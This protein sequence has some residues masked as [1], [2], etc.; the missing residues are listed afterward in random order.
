MLDKT[1]FVSYGYLKSAEVA[2]SVEQ[3][4]ENPRVGGSIP[5]LGTFL[6]ASFLVINEPVRKI[7]RAIR[8]PLRKMSCELSARSTSWC[9]LN[10]V[11]ISGIGFLFLSLHAGG[12][13]EQAP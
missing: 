8:H 5:S 13:F 3:G 1:G 6:C 10:S 9:H 7:F 12:F 2:Q 4:T 11:C